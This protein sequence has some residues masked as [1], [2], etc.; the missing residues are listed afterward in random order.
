MKKTTIVLVFLF[1]AIISFSQSKF[2][3]SGYNVTNSDLT[4]NTYAKDS[5]AN[6]LVIYEFGNSYFDQDDFRLKTEIKRKIKILNRDGFDQANVSILLYK[7]SDNKEKVTK[8][9]GTTTNTNTNGTLDIQKLN[10]SQIFTEKYND[11]YTL[12]KFTMP[13]IK[14]GSVIK[15]SYTLDTPFIFN[16]RNWYFQTNIPT[17]Y[18]E[19]HASIPA[20]YDYNIKL[21]GKTPLNIN[22]NDV[23]KECLKSSS[24]AKA[25]CF[26]T[27][28]VMKDVPAFI[29]EE[30][31][32]TKENY[33]S[34][35][36][37]ELKVYTGFDGR[38]DNITKSWKTVDKELKT[39]K[40]IGRQ[41]NKGSVV[42]ELLS[43]ETTTEKDQLK[44]AQAIVEYVQNN[45]KW[46]EKFN[47]FGDLSLKDLIKNKVGR[48]SE[49]N[50]LL[51]NLLN[52][53]NI[54]VLPILMSTRSNG[55]PTRIF[56]V[57]SEF[58]Y[59]IIQAKIAGET[60]FL[61]AT[62]PYLS[63]GQLPYRC[64]NQYGRLLD[65]KTGSS[66]VDIKPKD[67]FSV[68][69]KVTSKINETGTI[70]GS[71]KHQATG[72]K[73]SDLKANYF[74]NKS[75]Y[76]TDYQNENTNIT[77]TNHEVK[78]TSKNSE[79][80]IEVVDFEIPSETIG[81][82]IYINPFITTFFAENPFKLQERTYPIDF[83]YKDS[84]TYIYKL[85]YD[86]NLFEVSEVPEIKKCQLPNGKGTLLFNVT[87]SDSKIIIY[88]K[89]NFK[90][91]IYNQ[92][93]YPYLKEYF[94]TIVD[95]QKN[96][97]IVLKKK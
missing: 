95:L 20:N 45:Y 12:V 81:N 96:S 43:H 50:L 5:T 47:I 49:I 88:F 55:L 15:Y 60:Y 71:I 51:F 65:L 40:S 92:N 64:L 25:D 57:I 37:Y 58:N 73:S 39:E 89:F 32:T 85:D 19:Y 94:S 6:A 90:E 72:Y 79:E 17:L 74:K 33:I 56:P 53:N 76:L 83:G 69:Y 13:N 61:D 36:E 70:N 27:V 62:S 41:L 82:A 14:E 30:Y 26:K 3:A 18:S 91:A 4:K 1:F 44:K 80:F 54:E 23:E 59:I 93:Y 38:R 63:F 48:A 42:K 7:N 2:N 22:T 84:Y 35:V 16:Y 86:T 9:I 87:K 11:N 68:S 75:S 52:E 46:D 10:K 21:V 29:D 67:K 66:W 34:K 77:I 97:L 31:M 78:T 8:I 28:Y 24:G